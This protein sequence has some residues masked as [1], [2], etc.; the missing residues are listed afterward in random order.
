MQD[1]NKQ[2]EQMQNSFLSVDISIRNLVLK[3]FTN[4]LHLYL[5]V[6]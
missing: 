4:T 5:G 1:L 2:A 3:L 6:M